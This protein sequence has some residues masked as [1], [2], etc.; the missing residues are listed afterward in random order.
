M[1][2]S[3]IV[4]KINGFIAKTGNDQQKSINQLVDVFRN[5]R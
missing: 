3:I 5:I 1:K 2:C 4:L